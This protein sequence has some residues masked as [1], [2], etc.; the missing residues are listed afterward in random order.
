M[1]YDCDLVG[2][3]RVGSQN[4]EFRTQNSKL[5]TQNSELALHH[6]TN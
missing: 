6:L 4:P 5:E 1:I 3:N 2:E